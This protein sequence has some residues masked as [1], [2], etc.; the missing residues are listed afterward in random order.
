[1][2]TLPILSENA[3]TVLRERYLRRDEAGRLIEDPAAMLRRVASTVAEPAHSFGEDA[4]FWEARFFERLERLEFLSNS[5][6]LMNAGLT[7][8]QLAVCPV[9]T[10][11]VEKRASP[12]VLYHQIGFDLLSGDQG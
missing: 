11:P 8:G 4:A 2:S 9:F 5:P 7:G 10:R 3:L 6:P 12:S 1:M